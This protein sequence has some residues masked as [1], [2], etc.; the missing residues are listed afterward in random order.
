MDDMYLFAKKVYKY[1]I[2]QSSFQSA[3]F[4]ARWCYVSGIRNV[5]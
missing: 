3:Q 1:N 2:T 4:E 5:Y